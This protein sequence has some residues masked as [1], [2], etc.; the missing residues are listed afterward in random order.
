MHS[1]RLK[2]DGRDLGEG[3]TV[4]F[5]IKLNAKQGQLDYAINAVLN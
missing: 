5:E 2:F 4:K 1:S 3:A